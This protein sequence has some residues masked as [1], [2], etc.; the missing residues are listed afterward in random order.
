MPN[1]YGFSSEGCIP[2]NCS[3]SGSL[4]AQCDYFGRCACK[5]E[6][7]TG[8]KCDQCSINHFNFTSGCKKCDECYNLVKEKFDE[9]NSNLVELEIRLPQLVLDN[10]NAEKKAQNVEFERRYEQLKTQITKIH[11]ELLKSTIKTN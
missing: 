4:S 7:V 6:K 3:P 10:H 11:E 9:L 2:C 5:N 8:K 1:H